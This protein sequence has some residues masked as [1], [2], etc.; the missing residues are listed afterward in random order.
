MQKKFIFTLAVVSGLVFSIA[1]NGFARE[2]YD[3]GQRTYEYDEEYDE[4]YDEER[5]ESVKMPRTH[6]P[7]HTPQTHGLTGA[8][9]AAGRGGSGVGGN[10]VGGTMRGERELRRIDRSTVNEV[11]SDWND[12]PKD[13]AQKMI[14]KYGMP[15]EVTQNRLIWH[16]NNPWRK[17]EVVNEE[18][19]HS[20]PEEHEDVLIQTVS[21]DVPTDK[22]DDLIKYNESII[23]EKNRGELGSQ[24]G[25]EEMNIL[26]LNLADNVVKGKSDVREARNTFEQQ[27]TDVMDGKRASL[28][29]SLQFRTN[30]GSQRGR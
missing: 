24:C 15:D 3:R 4:Y 28:A 6:A 1:D 21:Y 20:F 16:N 10:I 9:G 27:A 17:T 25:S 13:V 30:S 29:R 7:G 22:V 23:I 19:S 5:E 18:V 11:I 12:T 14:D 8:E 26:A 2:R